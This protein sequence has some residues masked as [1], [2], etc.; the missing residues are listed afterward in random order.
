MIVANPF[1]GFTGAPASYPVGVTAAPPERQNRWTVAFR[2]ILAFPALLLAAA[3]GG[4]LGLVGLF[5]W[6]TGL[7]TARIPDGLRR[8][9]L[10]VLRYNAQTYGYALGLLTSRYPYAGPPA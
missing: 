6:F 3:L 2:F 7:F 9:G 5:A 4:A 10:F 1:P 8:L